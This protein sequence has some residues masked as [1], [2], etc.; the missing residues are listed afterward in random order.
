MI[1]RIKSSFVWGDFSVPL[2][3]RGE[4]VGLTVEFAFPLGE[5]ELIF[6][7]LGEGLFL[8]GVLLSARLVLSA[9]GLGNACPEAGVL[10]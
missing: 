4:V 5:F 10:R 1:K 8:G 3:R 7:L 9:G 6:F 2:F